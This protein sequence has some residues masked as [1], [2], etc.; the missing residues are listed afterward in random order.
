MNLSLDEL[1]W[2]V[3]TELETVRELVG[4]TWDQALRLVNGPAIALPK[5]G[6]K[7]LRPALCLL[8]A[9]VIDAPDLGR[10]ANLA[11]AMELLHVAALTHDDVVDR[12]TLR[13]GAASLNALWDSRTAVLSGDYLVARSVA[14]LSNLGSCT[15]IDH[16]FEAVR[17]M[18][19]GE[20]SLFGRDQTDVTQEECLR[21]A[22]QK[23]ATL[24]AVTCTGPT[25]LHENGGAIYRDALHHFGTALGIAFQLVDDMLDITRSESALGKP[26]CGDIVE[27]KRTLPILFMRE[28]LGEAEQ[29]RLDEMTGRLLDDTDRQWAADALVRSGGLARTETVARQFA[30]KACAALEALPACRVKDCMNGLVEFVLVRGF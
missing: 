8:S 2:P 23:T 9:S 19:E 27:G 13:R 17:T 1:Y 30:D 6:G 4:Q 21:L 24:F 12:A 18:T 16:V 22:D 25:Y 29:R 10:F 3:R 28:G 14:L 11:A 20:L 5:S 7:L 26:S 15:L